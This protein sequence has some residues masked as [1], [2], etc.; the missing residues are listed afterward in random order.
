MPRITRI[1]RK[2]R[3]VLED[4]E[5]SGYFIVVTELFEELDEKDDS[6]GVDHSADASSDHPVQRA[7]DHESGVE[8]PD[9]D[10]DAPRELLEQH[11]WYKLPGE[12]RQRPVVITVDR[13]T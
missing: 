3:H 8:K 4:M 9:N 13:Q 11:R 6:A 1:L 10:P 2:Y 12:K 5:D 7:I